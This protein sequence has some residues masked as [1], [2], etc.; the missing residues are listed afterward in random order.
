[1]I[2]HES[3]SAD[4]EGTR[5]HYLIEGREG[6]L[7]IVLLHG[8]SFS[9]LT[10]KQIGTLTALAEGGYLGYALDLPGFG[11]SAPLRGSPQT[12]LG[13]LLDRL[14][15]D[16][17]VLVS[18]SL[19]GRFA[20]PLVTDSP[21]RLCAF[22]AIAPVAIPQ[23]VNQ[24]HRITI[25][26]LAVWGEDDRIIPIQQADLLIQSVSQGRKVV[27]AGGSHAPYMSDPKAFHAVLLEFLDELPRPTKE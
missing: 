15:I 20:L 22:V 2:E 10:W 17:P 11:K 23:Y 4:V 8:A 3:R 27:I 25:P 21:A 19:S 1:M 6:G 18:P 7:P 14:E 16:R 12:W 5:V 24:L 9:A 26:V 13:S